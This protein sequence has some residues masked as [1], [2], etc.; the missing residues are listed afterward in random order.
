MMIIEDFT[1][2][3]FEKMA[4]EINEI[5]ESNTEDEILKLIGNALHDSGMTVVDNN[6]KGI[7]KPKMYN[8]EKEKFNI[9]KS[10]NFVADTKS[11]TPKDAKKE[12]KKFWKRFKEELQEAI[13][14]DDKIKKLM[15]G[16]GTLKEYLVVGIPMVLAALGVALNPIFL[17]IIAAVFA[18]IIKVGFRAYCETE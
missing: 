16:K 2:D 14:S 7:I 4:Q 1:G 5:S 13:C 8:P 17:A 12:G 11:L 18:L 3:D 6:S 10:L 15:D 9:V